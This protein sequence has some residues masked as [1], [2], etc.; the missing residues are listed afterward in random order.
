MNKDEFGM[1]GGIRTP[2]INDIL[3]EVKNL[4]ENLSDI[5]QKLETLI[6]KKTF[7]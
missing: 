3:M 2:S 7:I 6:I 5:E 4:K 1:A